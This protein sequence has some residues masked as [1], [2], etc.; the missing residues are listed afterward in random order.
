MLHNNSFFKYEFTFIFKTITGPF[1]SIKNEFDFKKKLIDV[2]C[3]LEFHKVVMH[4][5]KA[6]HTAWLVETFVCVMMS[7]R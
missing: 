1:A 4:M 7:S 3:K 5:T 2:F 6:F